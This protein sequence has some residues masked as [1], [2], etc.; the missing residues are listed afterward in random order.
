MANIGMISMELQIYQQVVSAKANNVYDHKLINW[1]LMLY[2]HSRHDFV[3]AT[4][5]TA[6]S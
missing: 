6:G 3:C 1:W 2:S 5:L 4:D